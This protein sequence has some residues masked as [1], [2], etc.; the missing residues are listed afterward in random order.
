MADKKVQVGNDRE[1]AQS[2]AVLKPKI[3]LTFKILTLNLGNIFKF[4][5]WSGQLVRIQEF[6]KFHT[7]S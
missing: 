7:L 2:E 3:I 4:L 5:F 1:K 6:V